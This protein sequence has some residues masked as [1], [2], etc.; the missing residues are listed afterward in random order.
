MRIALNTCRILA[1]SD[2][3]NNSQLLYV[4]QVAVAFEP[5]VHFC[6]S[7]PIYGLLIGKRGRGGRLRVSRGKVEALAW[8]RTRVAGVAIWRVTAPPPGHGGIQSDRRYDTV[9][10]LRLVRA[11][12]RSWVGSSFLT[13]LVAIERRLLGRKLMRKTDPTLTPDCPRQLAVWG[14]QSSQDRGSRR[15]GYGRAR[16]PLSCKSWLQGREIHSHGSSILRLKL[17]RRHRR[18]RP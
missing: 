2:F 9:S 3:E 1:A 13:F 6:A 14:M 7:F 17:K 15:A 11:Q 12:T 8:S 4:D 18:P 5:A 10:S 16:R